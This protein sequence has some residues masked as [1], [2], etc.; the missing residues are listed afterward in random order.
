MWCGPAVLEERAREEREHAVRMMMR[1]LLRLVAMKLEKWISCLRWWHHFHSGHGTTSPA[2]CIKKNSVYLQSFKLDLF[3]SL[4]LSMAFSFSLVYTLVPPVSLAL[5]AHRPMWC[6]HPSL[7]HNEIINAVWL[8]AIWREGSARSSQRLNSKQGLAGE[9]NYVTFLWA[10]EK[11][12]R[13]INGLLDIGGWRQTYDQ[14]SLCAVIFG[15]SK[16]GLISYYEN[17]GNHSNTHV[18]ENGLNQYWCINEVTD[19]M[20]DVSCWSEKLS[21]R[22]VV[23][24]LGPFTWKTQRNLNVHINVILSTFKHTL[25]YR[26]SHDY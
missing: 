6:R 9:L 17:H 7:V 3:S 14:I 4:H 16:D 15:R 11:S 24:M 8:I 20:Y 13:V 23:H 25:P 10:G 21:A 1:D 2:K 12:C 19:C 26:L 22:W 5:S 18:K